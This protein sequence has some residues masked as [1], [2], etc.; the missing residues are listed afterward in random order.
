MALRGPHH[1]IAVATSVGE[2]LF[3]FLHSRCQS[4]GGKLTAADLE[5]ARSQFINTLPNA[6]DFFQRMDQF[7]MVASGSTAPDSFAKDSILATVLMACGQKPARRA[8]EMQL[9]RLGAVWLN[10][11]FGA[12]AHLARQ[13]VATADERLV[14][15]YAVAAVKFGAKL[16][17]LD[18][19]KQD[20]VQ[21]VVR[22][23]LAPLVAPN[24]PAELSGPLSDLLSEQIARQRGIPK[25]DIS[26]VTEQQM[27]NF[28][29]W[30][31]PQAM[32]ALNSAMAA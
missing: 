8:F 14:K 27:R 28:L 12:L 15:A 19:L 29:S 9:T 5:Q 6:F 1:S 24:A 30:L 11:F 22:E 4:A 7:C 25:P 20:A 3:R 23:C 17:L 26:K 21:A 2:M 32:L 18:L 16:S 31:P 10:Q 13:Q